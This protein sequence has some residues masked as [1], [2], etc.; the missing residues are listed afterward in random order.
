MLSLALAGSTVAAQ[1]SDPELYYGRQ[2]EKRI[3]HCERKALLINSGSEQVRLHAQTARKQADYYTV[4]KDRLIQEMTHKHLKQ[5]EHKVN[6]F[7]IEAFNAENGNT[8]VS[9]SEMRR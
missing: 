3:F 5:R 1:D 6:A 2:I 7:L 8:D 4:N 9:Y